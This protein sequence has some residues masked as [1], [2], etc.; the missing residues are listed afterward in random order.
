[1]DQIMGN[2]ACLHVQLKFKLELYKTVSGPPQNTLMK[3]T[4]L[5]N[6]DVH[7]ITIKQE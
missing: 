3:F 6:L 2:Q 7:T 1:M 4:Y 5:M